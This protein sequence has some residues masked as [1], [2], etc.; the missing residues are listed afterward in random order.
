MVIY[1]EGYKSGYDLVPLR[2][3]W[4]V[5]GERISS[6][7]PTI[8]T[9]K[10]ML[11]AFIGTMDHQG[12]D[13]GATRWATWTGVETVERS[14]VASHKLAAMMHRSQTVQAKEKVATLPD[15]RGQSSQGI[16]HNTTR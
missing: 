4:Q 16:V 7:D 15:Q 2:A 12:N 3:E 13:N 1:G 5:I 14:D 11:Q 9:I 10:G 8:M 6:G